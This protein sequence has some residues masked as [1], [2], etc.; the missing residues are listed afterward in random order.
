MKKYWREG[1]PMVWATGAAM[2]LT[3]MIAAT[4][5]VVILVCS[6]LVKLWMAVF[7]RKLGR[8]IGSAALTA[9]TGLDDSSYAQDDYTS[10]II[11][12]DAISPGTGNG[13]T[14][15]VRFNT[16]ADVN[17]INIGLSLGGILVTPGVGA[18]TSSITWARR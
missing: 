6:I 5:I 4:L 16:A 9:V 14:G 10:S 2:A 3:L 17:V 18:N 8:R 1:E 15:T 12:T 11:H 13:T 7:N